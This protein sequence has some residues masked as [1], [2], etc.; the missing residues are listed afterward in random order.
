MNWIDFLYS[1]NSCP[2]HEQFIFGHTILTLVKL[3]YFIN[4]VNFLILATD[5]LTCNPSCTGNKVC[6]NYSGDPECVCADGFTGE[7]ICIGMLD[8]FSTF[9]NNYLLYKSSLYGLS[10]H[11]K[12]NVM[13]TQTQRHWHSSARSLQDNPVRFFCLL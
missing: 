8:N 3:S 7:D 6:Q 2:K 12:P 4:S 5:E 10:L 9:L 1:C 13:S 11:L